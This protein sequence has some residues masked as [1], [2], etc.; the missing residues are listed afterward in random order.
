MVNFFRQYKKNI[1]K[2]KFVKF[3]KKRPKK[4]KRKTLQGGDWKKSY[5]QKVQLP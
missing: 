2:H 3:L 1:A 4:E 5:I